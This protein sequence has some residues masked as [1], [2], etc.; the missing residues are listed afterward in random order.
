MA[1]ETTNKVRIVPVRTYNPVMGLL[2]T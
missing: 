1:R 2:H